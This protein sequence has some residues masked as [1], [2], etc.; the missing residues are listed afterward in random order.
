MQPKGPEGLRL[1]E[2]DVEATPYSYRRVHRQHRDR[3][4]LIGLVCLTFSACCFF[5]IIHHR[6]LYFILI[7]NS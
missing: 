6:I 1:Q 4:L 7:M 3:Q 2:E 5:I